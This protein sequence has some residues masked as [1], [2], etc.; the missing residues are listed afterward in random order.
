MPSVRARL[1]ALGAADETKFKLPKHANPIAV[2]PSNGDPYDVPCNARKA[3]A[4]PV[5]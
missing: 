4:M 5:A 2:M 3:P 1:T